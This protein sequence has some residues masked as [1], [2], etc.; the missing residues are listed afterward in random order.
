M[1][2]PTADLTSIILPIHNQEDHVEAILRGYLTAL[3]PLLSFELVVVTNG[4][5]DGSPQ[6]IA[7]LAAE[8]PHIRHVDLETGG[9]G[10]AVKAGLAAARGDRLCYTNAARTTP[11]I[12]T[13]ML[14][15][16]VAYP[17]VVLKAN[18]RIR[19]SRR[20]RLGSLIYNLECRALFDLS[21]WDINGTPKI[22]PRSFGKLL[23]LRR[24][25]DLIDAEFNIV[26]RREDYPVIEV[27]ILAT[28][29]HGGRSTTGYR[30]ALR[31]YIGAY[32]LRRELKEAGAD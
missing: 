30:S 3:A 5:T 4:C 19:E 7:R 26:C 6:L 31:M 17:A 16:A 9:W 24:G 21:V 23:E 22:F 25:D 13:L 32:E 14:A 27:P 1:S 11:E 2:E 8:D 28:E 10:K 20:R 29:R 18:R 15:Y 12:L